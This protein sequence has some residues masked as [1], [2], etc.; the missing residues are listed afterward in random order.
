MINF[1]QILSSVFF[2][3]AANCLCCD[4]ARWVN[5]YDCL[6]DACRKKIQ[7]LSIPAASCNRCLMPLRPGKPCRFC[8]SSVMR[9]IDAVYAPFRYGGEI[10]TLIHAF[11]FQA[12]DEAIPTLAD[13][14]A[15]SLAERKFD[16]IVP[17]PIH[18]KRLMV[19]GVNQTRL[20][21]DALSVRTG[22][23]VSEP[24]IRTKYVRPQSRTAWAERRKNVN[25]VFFCRDEVSGQ[26][27]LLIDDV[28]T[29][30]STAAACARELKKSGASKVSLCVCAIVYQS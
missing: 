18:K 22:I 19:R 25:N 1:R 17:V 11:K 14:M 6:C 12:C 28:R 8:A 16:W 23:P 27:I 24:L 10:R 9:C 30:G 26:R 21:A 4:E 5:E 15:K 29:T 20:L 3:H 7:K 13:G 2:P